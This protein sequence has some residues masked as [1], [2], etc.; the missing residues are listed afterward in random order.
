MN[1]CIVFL[2]F[3]VN[4]ALSCLTYW[5][6]DILIVFLTMYDILI[7]TTV[8]ELVSTICYEDFVFFICRNYDDVLTDCA[9]HLDVAFAFAFA[10]LRKTS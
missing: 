6:Y 1:D 8:M 4:L 5:T 9:R 2:N 10:V 7:P 3:L